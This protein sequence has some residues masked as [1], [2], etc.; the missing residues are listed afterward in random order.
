MML[1]QLGM[2]KFYLSLGFFVK[3]S[4]I[5]SRFK[6]LV[7]LNYVGKLYVYVSEYLVYLYQFYDKEYR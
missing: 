1:L 2:K 7:F 5:M 3:D 6:V 4:D